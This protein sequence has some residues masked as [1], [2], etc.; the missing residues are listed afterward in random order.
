[1]HSLQ[2]PNNHLLKEISAWEVANL[3][4]TERIEQQKQMIAKLEEQQR[5]I[6]KSVYENLV[7]E[8]EK[9]K[10]QIDDLKTCVYG[11]I[12]D[13]PTKKSNE[14]SPNAPADGVL[15]NPQKIDVLKQI[16]AT[17][18][19]VTFELAPTVRRLQQIK[20][21]HENKILEELQ[22]LLNRQKLQEAT[23]AA[24][25]N[26]SSRFNSHQWTT[27]LRPQARRSEGFPT[28][29][30]IIQRTPTPDDDNYANTPVSTQTSHASASLFAS[31]DNDRLFENDNYSKQ[32]PSIN[33]KPNTIIKPQVRNF[34]PKH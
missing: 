27:Q 5:L 10:Q 8:Q 3:R 30:D 19:D 22:E 23:A 17:L 31:T 26:R 15:E 7:R 13:D 29:T 16:N 4:L 14:A 11:S 33:S 1:M 2:D 25:L 24:A 21:I 20:E 18:V 32:F 28:T 34:A 12:N 6:E 9:Q